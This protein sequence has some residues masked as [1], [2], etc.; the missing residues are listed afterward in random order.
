MMNPQLVAARTVDTGASGPGTELPWE[1]QAEALLMQERTRTGFAYVLLA[2]LIAI[3]ITAFLAY[4]TRWGDL[5]GMGN[6]VEMIFAP[7]IALLGTIVGFY[8]GQQAGSGP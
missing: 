3:V 7:V 6:F 8:Y 2:L 5:E 4:G 1:V